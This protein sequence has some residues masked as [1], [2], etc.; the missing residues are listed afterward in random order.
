MSKKRLQLEA[1]PED[2]K[3]GKAEG[4]NAA[5]V[6]IAH[7]MLKDKMST[8]TIAKYTGITADEIKTIK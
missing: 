7:G 1:K 8:A 6:E 5:K 3:K 2:S 4:E